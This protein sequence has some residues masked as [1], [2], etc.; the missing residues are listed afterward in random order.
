MARVYFTCDGVQHM[1]LQ[2]KRLCFFPRICPNYSPCPSHNRSQGHNPQESAW[3]KHAPLQPSKVAKP[4]QAAQP[5]PLDEALAEIR[6]S[7]ASIID[8]QVN[9][10]A[11]YILLCRS[12]P[13]SP[14]FL[15]ATVF[16]VRVFYCAF[17]RQ[18]PRLLPLSLPHALQVSV[19]TLMLQPQTLNISS[20]T[21][22]RKAAS[23]VPPGVCS[24]STPRRHS[25]L[26]PRYCFIT[27]NPNTFFCSISPLTLCPRFVLQVGSSRLRQRK[28]LLLLGQREQSRSIRLRPKTGYHRCNSTP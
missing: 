12:L 27:T 15:S 1:F 3:D 13:L 6:N 8:F 18:H 10:R 20:R 5:L 25:S 4:K 26:C 22:A 16:I 17:G 9:C 24:F 7:T 14:F 19:R 2:V 11:F 23:H 21:A 28:L